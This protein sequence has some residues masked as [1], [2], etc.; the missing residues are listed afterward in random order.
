[1][2][3]FLLQRDNVIR[4]AYIVDGCTLKF[5][6]IHLSCQVLHKNKNTFFTDEKIDTDDDKDKDKYVE[7]NS[8][9]LIQSQK[10]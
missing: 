4:L 10:T 6:F 1:M 8:S 5:V 2:F 7:G 3:F 9:F